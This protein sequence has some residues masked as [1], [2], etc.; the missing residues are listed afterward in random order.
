MSS[1]AKIVIVGA[2]PGGLTL[3]TLLQKYG[4]SVTI[5]EKDL[6]S[7]HR[8]QG[9]SLDLHEDS[10]LLA[11]REAGLFE[12]FKAVAR[13]EDQGFRLLDKNG[14][15]YIDQV[16]DINSDAQRN[17]RPE[18]DRVQLRNILLRAV[19][20]E[21]IVWDRKVTGISE[22]EDCLVDVSFDGHPSVT[23]N[24]VIGA[25]GAWSRIR[26]FVSDVQPL[27]TN[28]SMVEVNIADVDSRRP[29]IAKLVGRGSLIAAAADKALVAQRNGGNN[30]RIYITLR[31][32]ETWTKRA[33]RNVPPF[34]RG[35]RGARHT[36][37]Q[38][39]AVQI[40]ANQR[41]IHKEAGTESQRNDAEA[42]RNPH[43][44]LDTGD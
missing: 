20:P 37:K 24:L 44:R 6:S 3:A 27:Y 21:T 8:S 22:R 31:V 43:I 16:A 30:M 5:Y 42:G 19:K 23:A 28:C 40:F 39:L 26:P 12:E 11:L 29:S 41:R 25:D 15:V 17:D 14:R 36:H 35:G 13:Y 1:E 33:D 38:L 4:I 32:P 10:G 9:G 18:I 7:A 2:G 34:E